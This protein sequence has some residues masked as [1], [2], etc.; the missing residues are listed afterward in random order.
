MYTCIICVYVNLYMYRRALM[1][2]SRSPFF[3]EAYVCKLQAD[4]ERGRAHVCE[5]LS[6]YS[7]NNPTLSHTFSFSSLSFSPSPPCISLSSCS[8]SCLCFPFSTLRTYT[9]THVYTGTL[10]YAHSHSNALSSPPPIKTDSK[11]NTHIRISI[12]KHIHRHGAYLEVAR[13]R[14]WKP[15][16]KKTQM[17]HNFARP[18][19]N[20]NLHHKT[21]CV[22]NIM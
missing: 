15:D 21:L 13:S 17:M 11:K 8:S 7:P 6:T 1:N 9:H 19:V 4:S 16:Q 10:T 2:C 5:S 3:L 22:K 20:Q 14:G 12:Y 18:V